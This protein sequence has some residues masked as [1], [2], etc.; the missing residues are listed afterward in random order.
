MWPNGLELSRLASP[1]LVSHEILAPGWPGR[2]QRVVGPPTVVLGLGEVVMS[3][4][5][6]EMALQ[7][8]VMS[9]D[10]VHAGEATGGLSEERQNTFSLKALLGPPRVM[11]RSSLRSAW[12]GR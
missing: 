4:Y 2:L 3:P 9:E 5:G 11:R 10:I 6:G 8:N 7:A 12:I 1:N